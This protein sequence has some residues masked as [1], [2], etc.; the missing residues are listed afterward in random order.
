MGQGRAEAAQPAKPQVLRQPPDFAEV[1]R[2]YFGFVWRC[3]RGLGVPERQLDDAAQD[4]FVAVH[5]RLDEFRGESS[6]RTWLYGILRN[7]A[8]N[9]RR[10]ERRRGGVSALD[11]EPV[12]TGPRPDESAQDRQ[13]ADFV[14]GFVA[15]LD[16]K[17]RDVF[18]LGLIEQ[19]TMPEVAETLGVPLNT[20]YTR[21]RSVR[22]EFT[23][24]LARRR[25]SE[26]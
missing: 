24:A 11:S 23:R 1:Y 5:R 9:Q 2:A 25:E 15:G 13:A 20:A 8:A 3:L 7:V 6:L 22:Q 19:L 12:A 10:S 16:D 18:V 26:P 4:V 17:K 21:L 14:A